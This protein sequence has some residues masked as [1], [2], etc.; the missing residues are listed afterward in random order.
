MYVVNAKRKK[1]EEEEEKK[2]KKRNS[3][4]VITNRFVTYAN[5]VERV[6]SGSAVGQRRK[7]AMIRL[8]HVLTRNNKVAET[9]KKPIRF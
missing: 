4:Y 1:E 9:Y 7:I 6:C 8:E 2:R 5:V 3:T